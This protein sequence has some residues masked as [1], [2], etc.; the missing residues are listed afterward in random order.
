MELS[1]DEIK[2]YGRHLILPEIGQE[3]QLKLKKAK[4]CNKCVD[5]GY[6]GR[7]ALHE[8]LDATQEMKRMV[9]RREPA[10]DLRIQ[11]MKDGMT[12]LKQ[13]GI[14]KIFQGHCDLKQVLSVCSV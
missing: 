1:K 3:G 4:G 12:T 8:L 9:M 6:S 14:N 10:E 5:T 13:D 7:I 11:A 2:R